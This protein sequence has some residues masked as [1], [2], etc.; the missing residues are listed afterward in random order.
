MI[1][2]GISSERFGFLRSEVN[3][4]REAYNSRKQTKKEQDVIDNLSETSPYI[5]AVELR[6]KAFVRRDVSEEMFRIDQSLSDEEKNEIVERQIQRHY[7][8][9]F[10]NSE[11]RGHV[12]APHG[13]RPEMRIEEWAVER[14]FTDFDENTDIIAK[15]VSNN[16]VF[17]KNRFWTDVNRLNHGQGTSL[18]SER[19]WTREFNLNAIKAQRDSI[20]LHARENELLDEHDQFISPYLSIELHGKGNKRGRDIEFGIKEVEG[21][22][23]INPHLACWIADVL[24]NKCRENNFVDENNNLPEINLKTL[25]GPY[26]GSYSLTRLRHG[27]ELFDFNGFGENFNALQFECAP[28]VREKDNKLFGRILNEILEEFTNTFKNA[29]DVFALESVYGEMYE[30]KKIAERIEM[31]SSDRVLLTDDI[32]KGEIRLSK[33]IR[34]ELGVEIDGDIEINGN[35]FTVIKN[36]QVYIKSG[37]AFVLHKDFEHIQYN[38]DKAKKI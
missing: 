4:A 38:M 35:T 10:E 31:F 30:Q 14:S 28:W 3:K 19:A 29:E 6:E 32:E 8:A 22:G 9:C 12:H 24:R 37:F 21:R 17:N 36:Q 23:P 34:D 27:D 25:R 26:S 18:K 20:A 7:E 1:R 2:K 33:S 15:E 16:L 11:I 13:I 5:N